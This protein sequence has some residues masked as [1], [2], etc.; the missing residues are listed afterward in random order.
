MLENLRAHRRV[1]LV[2][3]V[4]GRV[5]SDVTRALGALSGIDAIAVL[6]QPVALAATRSLVVV[7]ASGIPFPDAWN[8][9]CT[10]SR[11][12]ARRGAR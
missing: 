9:A 11:R 5:G 12:P 2:V 7:E 4:L 6:T 1:D 8:Q 3:A 10:Q